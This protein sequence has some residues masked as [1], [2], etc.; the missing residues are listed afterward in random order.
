VST[1]HAATT[2]L[3][4]AILLVLAYGVARR[5]AVSTLNSLFAVVVSFTPLALGFTPLGATAVSLVALL[6]AVGATGWYR[7]VWWWDHVAHTFA[8]GVVGA[9]GYAAIATALAVDGTHVAPVFTDAFAILFALACGVLWELLEVAARDVAAVYGLHPLLTPYGVRDSL[10]DLFFDGVG[11]LLAVLLDVTVFVPLVAAL[12]V[13][14]LEA[15]DWAFLALLVIVL[16]LGE[17]LGIVESRLAVSQA[18][19]PARDRDADATGRNR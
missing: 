13:V 2:G 5:N 8:G 6:H 7:D 18:R 4:F 10:E 11:A 16:V 19:V 15:L 14:T 17:G 3:R 1:L 9:I 12:H